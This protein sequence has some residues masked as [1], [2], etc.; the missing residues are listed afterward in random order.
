[1]QLLFQFQKK[2]A[3]FFLEAFA[4]TLYIFFLEFDFLSMCACTRDI[5]M[6]WE[7]EK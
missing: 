6:D 7:R 4:H 5:D 2:N 3:T 1:M